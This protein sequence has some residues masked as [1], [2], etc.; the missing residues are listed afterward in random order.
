MRIFLLVL[1]IALTV[2]NQAEARDQ[3]RIVGSST[4][5]PFVTTV[6]EQ[7][8]R[9]TEFKTPIVE[10]TGTGG[11]FKLFCS[12]LGEETP[13]VSNASRRIKPTELVN[14]Y[15]NN[16]TDISEIKLGYDGIVIA[17]SVQGPNFDISVNE[18]FLGLAR[19]I[20]S[21]TDPG[22][23]VDNY[24]KSWDE[25]NPKLPAQ[26]IE[27]YGP[28]PTSG[29]RDAF[30]ELVMEG[31]CWH[32][33]AFK[34]NYPNSGDRKKAC[35][36]LREDGAY[37]DSGENDNL[38]VQ[39]LNVNPGALGIFGF[40]F[41]EENRNIV[42]GSKISGVPP[43]RESIADG[44]YIVSRPLFVYIK[45]GHVNKIPG[46]TDFVKELVSDGAIAP[47]GYLEEKG[48]IPLPD[49]ELRRVQADAISHKNLE[50]LVEDDEA[51]THIIKDHLGHN[52]ASYK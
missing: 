27:V 49:E 44:S 23:L 41:L 51:A 11:G 6:A 30:V 8:G 22:K 2:A 7:F 38:I 40:S 31:G 39:K 42:Q 25:I 29:T 14:C 28:P 4:V 35:H 33:E 24:Y 18:L 9:K 3:I 5:Y 21:K 52:I 46:I 34:A 17:N 16:V 15:K 1:L 13:D 45:S 20:P 50:N 26:K 47:F 37:I 10:S 32:L 48:L 36:I 12:G 19:K 43:T